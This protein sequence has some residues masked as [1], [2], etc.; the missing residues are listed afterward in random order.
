[1]GN[2]NSCED[3]TQSSDDKVSFTVMP[4]TKDR[5]DCYTVIGSLGSS[6]TCYSV[7][8]TCDRKHV[9]VNDL[10]LMLSTDNENDP[11]LSLEQNVSLFHTGRCKIGNLISD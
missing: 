6:D 10:F 1:M 3:P 8:L 4:L 11:K 9:T 5:K 7:K 2:N